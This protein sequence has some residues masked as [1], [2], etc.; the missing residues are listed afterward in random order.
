MTVPVVPQ[1]HYPDVQ[2]PTPYETHPDTGKLE[3]CQDAESGHR[4]AAPEP[5]ELR[6]GLPPLRHPHHR[7]PPPVIDT[8]RLGSPRELW[9]SPWPLASSGGIKPDPIF[10]CRGLSPLM[11][12]ANP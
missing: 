12:R 6:G 7:R 1:R 10:T 4:F 3:L 9:G 2:P 8:I 11:P 5:P